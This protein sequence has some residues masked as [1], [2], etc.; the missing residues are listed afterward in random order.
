MAFIVK[1]HV[2][3]DLLELPET[4]NVDKGDTV[5]IDCLDFQKVFNNIFTQVFLG[6]IK[7]PWDRRE[8]HD[9]FTLL[10]KR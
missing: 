3:A 5:A 8:G 4:T 1:S 9:M 10:M 7:F 2:V 6:K